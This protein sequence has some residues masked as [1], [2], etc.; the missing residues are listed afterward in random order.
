MILTQLWLNTNISE[1]LGNQIYLNIM[2][3]KRRISI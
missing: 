3:R 2:A 1:I